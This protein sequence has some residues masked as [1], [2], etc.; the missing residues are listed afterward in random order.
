MKKRQRTP[1]SKTLARRRV[2]RAE[3]GAG[4]MPSSSL[5]FACPHSF[6][7][8]DDFRKILAQESQTADL[9]GLSP[10][11]F[12]TRAISAVADVQRNAIPRYT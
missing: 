1:Q 8:H 10:S 7:I 4:W 5:K 6:V 9:D 12:G 3:L 11:L 2:S